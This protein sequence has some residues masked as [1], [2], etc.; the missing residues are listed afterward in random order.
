[1]MGLVTRS[2]FKGLPDGVGTDAHVA[3]YIPMSYQIGG[4]TI[5]TPKSRI[6]PVEASIEEAMRFI[7]TA[8]IMAKP[9]GSK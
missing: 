6:R 5:I 8:G 9:S 2:D 3:V 7:L 1:M 4:H